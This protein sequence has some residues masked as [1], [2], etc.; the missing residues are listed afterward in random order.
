MLFRP[1][2][3]DVTKSVAEGCDIELTLVGNRRNTFGPLHMLPANHKSSGPNMFVTDGE[4]WSD[5]FAL[6]KTG[7][8]KLQVLLKK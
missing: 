7:I 2:E 1:Y 8:Q 4:S 6:P 5:S 3:A